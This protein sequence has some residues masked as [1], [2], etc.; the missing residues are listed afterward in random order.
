MCKALLSMCVVGL[1]ALVAG[2]QS[3]DPV[4]VSK[5]FKFTAKFPR[6]PEVKEKRGTGRTTTTFSNVNQ[7]TG[8]LQVAVSEGEIRG[9]ESGEEIQRMLDN[10]RDHII[11]NARGKLTSS[12]S[13]TIVGK[14][15]G[16]AFTAKVI[17]PTGALRARVY[18]AGN[19]LYQ[20]WVVGL[21]E[22]VNSDEAT[23]FLESFRLTE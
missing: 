12:N 11:V 22:Y 2:C 21:P 6:P 9:D 8:V 7:K 16:R 5:E 10:T 3:E 20:V 15:P 1:L 4:F 13:I 17:Q 14:Y 18:I 23:A 19:R